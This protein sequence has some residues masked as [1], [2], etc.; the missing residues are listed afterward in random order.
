ME[1]AESAGDVV[2]NPA[3]V[4]ST[5][6]NKSISEVSY[7]KGVV[8]IISHNLTWKRRNMEEILVEREQRLV[9]VDSVEIL[10][11]SSGES[12]VAQDGDKTR[13]TEPAD[14]PILS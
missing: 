9:G 10:L 2:Y 1:V 7:H 12:A 5:R 6:S 13:E 8:I 3:T 11:R 14:N 4:C